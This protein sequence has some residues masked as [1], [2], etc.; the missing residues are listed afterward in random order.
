MLLLPERSVFGVG[1]S[2]EHNVTSSLYNVRSV[3]VVILF[4]SSH[5][6]LYFSLLDLAVS[7][8]MAVK[9]TST[10]IDL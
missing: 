7:K 10:I 2:R 5:F 4:S 8:M 6:L 9:S 3:F 1:F